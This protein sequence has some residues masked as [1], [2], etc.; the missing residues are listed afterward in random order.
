MGTC[1]RVLDHIERGNIDFSDIK[2]IVLDEADQMLKQGFKE[3]IDRILDEVK[4]QRGSELQ[5]CLFSATIPSWV[6]QVAATY[7]KR[8][9]RIV[10]LAQNLKNKT[11]KQVDHMAIMCPIQNRMAALGDVLTMYGK[12]G[13]VI[14]FTTTKQDANSLLL[15][16]RIKNNVE[17]M[18]GNIA[19]NQREVT[20]KRFKEGKFKV[21][22]ATDVASRGLDIPNVDLV[23]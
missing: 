12:G 14:V 1:G 7:M 16:D 2:T 9:V 4:R 8:N 21:L 10:D 6:R 13:K 20:M 23:I 15:S 5:I 17:V 19:Q 18:H 11:A 22:V 3:D